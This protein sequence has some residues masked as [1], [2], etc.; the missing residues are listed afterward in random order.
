MLYGVSEGSGLR[1][2]DSVSRVSAALLRLVWPSIWRSLASVLDSW[3]LAR[4]G[5]GPS[6]SKV[7][8]FCAAQGQRTTALSPKRPAK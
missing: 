8:S 5:N 7:A 3:T 4:P 6:P 1:R 2:E